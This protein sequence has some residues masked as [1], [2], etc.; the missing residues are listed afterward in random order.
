MLACVLCYCL[1]K[2][3]R[4]SLELS[5]P[6]PPGSTGEGSR[7]LS[8]RG[9]WSINSLWRWCLF[10]SWQLWSFPQRS[11]LE[12][13]TSEWWPS[14]GTS[15]RWGL[16]VTDQ[17]VKSGNVSP[18]CDSDVVPPAALSEEPVPGDAVVLQFSSQS[19]RGRRP[20]PHQTRRLR[21][22]PVLQEGR[23]RVQQP[24]HRLTTPATA[25][26]AAAPNQ[27]YKVKE[28]KVSFCPGTQRKRGVH[29]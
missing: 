3:R 25:V 8:L 21:V 22:L 13:E 20:T 19:R 29:L 11:F 12:T 17:R 2:K 18:C 4:G 15:W 5:I 7:M 27:N 26:A 28:S 1:F 6:E 16:K 10:S 14:A 24:W 23:L 9:T